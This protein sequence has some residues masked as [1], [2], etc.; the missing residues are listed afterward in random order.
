[1]YGRMVSRNTDNEASEPQ[2]TT[3]G[4]RLAE[5]LAE[6]GMSKRQLAFKSQVSYR[7]VCRIVAGD[8]LGNLDTWLRFAEALECD[9]SELIGDA[10]GEKDPR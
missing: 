7:T 4:H 1:M 9:V 8:R 2:T 5:K 10:N 6:L 3:T